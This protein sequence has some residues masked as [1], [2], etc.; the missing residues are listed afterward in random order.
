MT[1]MDRRG[2]LHTLLGGV[3]LVGAG[4]SL[5]P[6]D[7]AAALAGVPPIDQPARTAVGLAPMRRFPR[8]CRVR[9]ARHHDR[10]RRLDD[11]GAGCAG[12]IVDVA[13][14]GGAGDNQGGWHDDF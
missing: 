11:A 2:A 12:G 9:S 8:H 1:E 6:Q 5:W 13:T 14:A 7:A 10:G 3:V 4:V